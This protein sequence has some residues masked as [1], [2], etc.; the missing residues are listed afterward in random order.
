M[1]QQTRQ[2]I[3]VSELPIN[4]TQSMNCAIQLQLCLTW[5][6]RAYRTHWQR[7]CDYKRK[8]ILVLF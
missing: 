8:E 6:A 4:A 3:R 5:L 2:R 7:S 1:P